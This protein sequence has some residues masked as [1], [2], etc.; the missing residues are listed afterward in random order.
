MTFFSPRDSLERQLHIIG[1][2][3]W[4]PRSIQ[5]TLFIFEKLIFTILEEI[6]VI[7]QKIPLNVLE[8]FR[9]IYRYLSHIR[10]LSDIYYS[11]KEVRRRILYFLKLFYYCS[12]DR[13]RT[14]FFVLIRVARLSQILL[15]DLTTIYLTSGFSQIA[16]AIIEKSIIEIS[17]HL[18]IF[19]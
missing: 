10:I 3:S 19:Y 5:K 6:L 17:I 12:Y 13:E 11:N 9:D 2:R 15:G 4:E 18:L 7:Y 14:K 16:T 1:I 8:Y